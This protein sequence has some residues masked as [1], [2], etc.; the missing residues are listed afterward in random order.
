MGIKLTKAPD[1]KIINVRQMLDSQIAEI[2]NWIPSSPDYI[3][4][5]V[6]RHGNI[7]IAIGKPVGEGWSSLFNTPEDKRGCLVRIL[8]EG[9]TLTIT[10]NKG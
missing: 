7:L 2:V 5:I 1:T 4:A 8:D 6:Q 10:N 3:G 9:E